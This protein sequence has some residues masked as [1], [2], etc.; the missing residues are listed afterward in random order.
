MRTAPQ[1]NVADPCGSL[2]ILF[3]YTQKK[4]FL[5]SAQPLGLG[6]DVSYH[7]ATQ[8]GDTGEEELRP[9][10][11][12]FCTESCSEESS[13]VECSSCKGWIH[14]RYLPMT[15]DLLEEWGEGDLPFTCR[16][17]AFDNYSASK[18]LER[19]VFLLYN[20]RVMRSVK[21]FRTEEGLIHSEPSQAEQLMLKTYNVDLPKSV[22][23]SSSASTVDNISWH[24]C[25]IKYASSIV[26]E[27]CNL[28]EDVLEGPSKRR[29]IYNIKARTQTKGQVIPK[30]NFAD[31][32]SAVEELQQTMPF[33][34]L[35]FRHRGTDSRY[36]EILL[37]PCDC[38]INSARF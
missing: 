20:T 3:N 6:L 11:G 31:Q 17:C 21:S 22:T 38:G 36:K 26:R 18:A 13:S 5:V 16:M 8:E 37:F 34:K 19:Y 2:K 32:V 27:I 24:H 7:H 28:N 1:R 23:M 15:Y 29:Q 35:I 12:I 30:A 9:L 33:V 4:E 10:P 25:G 14:W